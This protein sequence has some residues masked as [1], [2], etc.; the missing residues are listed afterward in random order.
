MRDTCSIALRIA[1]P[2]LLDLSAAPDR[3]ALIRYW[4]CLAAPSGVSIYSSVGNLNFN[5]LVS[6]PEDSFENND[7]LRTFLL[8]PLLSCHFESTSGGAASG[9]M[10]MPVTVGRYVPLRGPPGGR[11]AP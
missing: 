1:L 3:E 9:P 8:T 2:L 6:R 10:R 11:G 4:L 7:P 5:S